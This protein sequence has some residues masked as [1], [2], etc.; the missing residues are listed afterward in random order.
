ME[1][2]TKLEVGTNTM[3]TPMFTPCLQ[4]CEY[5]DYTFFNTMFAPFFTY[6]YSS[7]YTMFTPVFT[8][9]ITPIFTSCLHQ[10]FNLCLHLCIHLSVLLCEHYVYT[11]VYIYDYTYL[12]TMFTP[13]LPQCLKLMFTPRFTAWLFLCCHSQSRLTTQ[14]SWWWNGS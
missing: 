4:L 10:C 2:K 9:M 3:L 12:Y 5:H 14:W 1:D 7:A 6:V 13:I 11:Y 8:T